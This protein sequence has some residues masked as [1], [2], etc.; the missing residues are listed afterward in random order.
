MFVLLISLFYALEFQLQ[1]LFGCYSSY[2]Q[3]LNVYDQIFDM[4]TVL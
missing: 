1:I 2:I 4:K 3:I